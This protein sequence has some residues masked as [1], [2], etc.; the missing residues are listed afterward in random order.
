M[1]LKGLSSFFKHNLF[2][3]VN[4]HLVIF[5]QNNLQNY[6]HST[7]IETHAHDTRICS[8]NGREMVITNYI[9]ISEGLANC[10][11]GTVY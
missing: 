3:I 8:F 7:R 11:A 6:S 1:A 4:V 9:L 2:S 10:P 5:I